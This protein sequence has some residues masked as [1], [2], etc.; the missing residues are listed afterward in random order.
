MTDVTA[1]KENEIVLNEYATK[2]FLTQVSNRRHF[3][4]NLESKLQQSSLG[5]TTDAVLMCDLDHFK[6]INDSYGHP[7]GDEV[8]QSL[9][10][11]LR[12]NV[13]K[14]DLI[15]R[16]GGEEFAIFLPNTT[17]QEAVNFA[18]RLQHDLAMGP[19]VASMPDVTI[20]ISI[21]I[22]LINQGA[23]SVGSVLSR[24]DQALYQAKNA[25]RNRVVVATT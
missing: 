9:A 2:D 1:R 14:G 23:D 12:Q 4:A 15:G 3:L 16:I 19:V 25:G 21:G 5:P 18:N 17:A 8:L 13:R 11:I 10:R 7:I 22:A 20:T 6:N 24:S